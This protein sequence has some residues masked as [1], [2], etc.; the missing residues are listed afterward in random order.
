MAKAGIFKISNGKTVQKWYVLFRVEERSPLLRTDKRKLPYF[1]VANWYI[2][3]VIHKC[4]QESIGTLLQ[5][6]MHMYTHG[7]LI[8]KMLEVLSNGTTKSNL[9]GNCGLTTLCQETVGEWLIKLVFKYDYFVNN[10]YV[11]GH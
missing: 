11:G 6:M 7:T 10:Y 3:K 5:H 8:P 4:G 9:L 2:D 1:L